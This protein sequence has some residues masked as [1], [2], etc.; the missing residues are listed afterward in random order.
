MF[1]KVRLRLVVLGAGPPGPS[2]PFVAQLGA[3]LILLL[4]VLSAGSR[5][6]RRRA[7]NRLSRRATK[8]RGGRETR[9]RRRSSS[10]KPT[11]PSGESKCESKRTERGQWLSC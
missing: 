7:I 6:V 2:L 3:R 5:Y 4:L 11:S 8:G 1:G 9:K 10:P